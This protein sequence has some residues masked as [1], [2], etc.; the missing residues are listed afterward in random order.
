MLCVFLMLT[1]SHAASNETRPAC[2][3]NEVLLRLGEM[4]EKDNFAGMEG[5]AIT[6]GDIGRIRAEEPHLSLDE[7][8]EFDSQMVEDLKK[9]VTRKKGSQSLRF[10]KAVLGALNEN[11]SI[12]NIAPLAATFRNNTLVFEN[13]EGKSVEIRIEILVRSGNCWKVLIA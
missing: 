2:S 10:R 3:A 9:I 13:R 4:I 1:C 5:I 7:S 11:D 12:E 8:R 6:L